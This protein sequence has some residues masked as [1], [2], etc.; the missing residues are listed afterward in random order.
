MKAQ[1]KAKIRNP[2]PWEIFQ[3]L[4]DYLVARLKWTNP[5]DQPLV[6]VSIGRGYPQCHIDISIKS[7]SLD[8]QAAL[9]LHDIGI[10]D[11]LATSASFRN[12]N[13]DYLSIPWGSLSDFAKTNREKI[14]KWTSLRE[15]G[16]PLMQ[17]LYDTVVRD[18][19]GE[20][21]DDLLASIQKEAA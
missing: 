4:Q 13:D 20:Q 5:W 19:F 15:S 2:L 1:N 14:L 18:G 11:A 7:L 9:I 8:R 17:Q 10:P 12:F 16:K 6:T 21:L 3:Y